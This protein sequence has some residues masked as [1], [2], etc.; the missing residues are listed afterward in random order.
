MFSLSLFMHKREAISHFSKYFL[1]IILHVSLLQLYNFQAHAALIDMQKER[2]SSIFIPPFSKL[3]I[4]TFLATLSLYIS[5]G[6]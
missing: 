3:F 6:S 4:K 5:K 1:G 2:K